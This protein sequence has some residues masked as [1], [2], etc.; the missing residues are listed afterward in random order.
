MRHEHAADDPRGIDD[1]WLGGEPGLE[2]GDPRRQ[3]RPRPVAGAATPFDASWGQGA[4][5]REDERPPLQSSTRATVVRRRRIVALGVAGLLV[6][7][8]VGVAVVAT[9]DG[10]SSR[11]SVLTGTPTP[12]ATVATS[13]TTSSPTEETAP[14]TPAQTQ[15]ATPTPT[16]TLPAAGKLKEGDTGEAVV[17][18]QKALALLDLPVGEPDGRFGAATRDAVIAFQT[19]QGITPDGIVGAVTAQKLNDALATSGARG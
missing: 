8:G 16:V 19:A 14:T 10:A 3:R 15:P 7:A 11:A 4:P 13:P 17:T 1:D 2:W 9:K 6:V 5:A 12:T 18:L